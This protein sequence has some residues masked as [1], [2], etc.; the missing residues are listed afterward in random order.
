[1]PQKRLPSRRASYAFD[2]TLGF[3]ISS[4]FCLIIGSFLGQILQLPYGLLTRFVFSFTAIVYVI[5]LIKFA[6]KSKPVSRKKINP[7]SYFTIGPYRRFFKLTGGSKLFSSLWAKSIIVLAVITI[8]LSLYII[9]QLESKSFLYNSKLVLAEMPESFSGL[10]NCRELDECPNKFRD[11]ADV[12]RSYALTPGAKGYVM[13]ISKDNGKYN[14]IAS[15]GKDS[16]FLAAKSRA[17]GI[18]VEE[19]PVSTATFEPLF[20]RDFSQLVSAF[21]SEAESTVAIA[22][23][24]KYGRDSYRLFRS[25]HPVSINGKRMVVYIASSQ[26]FLMTPMQKYFLQQ[27]N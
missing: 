23:I 6:P 22:S 27:A 5:D 4:L 15:K 26:D 8:P 9:E 19:D 25:L 16:V 24:R 14:S 1:M 21:K 11:V 2:L 7:F 18:G 3:I 12:I 17:R 10:N 20:N 13:I